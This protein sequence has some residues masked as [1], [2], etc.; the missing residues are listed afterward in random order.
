M[1]R[2]YRNLTF[3]DH[4]I[5]KELELRSGMTG[6]AICKKLQLSTET[7]YAA[8]KGADV[9]LTTALKIAKFFGKTIE[10]IWPWQKVY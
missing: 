4:N 7:F 6:L 1:K 8:R 9:K 2:K 10:E 3:K 5:L